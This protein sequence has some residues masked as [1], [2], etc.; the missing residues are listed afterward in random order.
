MPED[1]FKGFKN[2]PVIEELLETAFRKANKRAGSLKKGRS[3][4]DRL[5]KKEF[6]RVEIAITHVQDYLNSIVKSVP[7]ISALHPFYQDLCQLLVSKDDLKLQL[8]RISGT[9]RVLEKLKNGQ[10][11]KIRKA[12]TKSQ[13]MMLRK[14]AMGRLKS[15]LTKLKGAFKYLRDARSSLRSIPVIHFNL[16]AV[17]FAGYPN[18]GK[19]SCINNFCGST[20][21]V[22]QYPFTTKEI[23]IGTFNDDMNSIQFIDTPGILDRPMKNRNAIELKAI[24]AIKHVADLII[25]VID[26][27]FNCGYELERQINLLEEFREN[28]PDVKMMIIINK[29]DLIS[30]DNLQEAWRQIEGTKVS[31]NTIVPYSAKKRIGE[32][33]V[34]RNIKIELG[35]T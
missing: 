21:K 29:V 27:T 19:S 13:A 3:A 7:D 20:I 32:E 28:L 23:M 17:V 31:I 30:N 2:I 26:P 11:S 8:G 18:V 12:T 5:K 6:T 35:I 1:P 25:F 33:E 22:A 9:I 34:L 16:P 15:M 24:L 4:S 14:E 10:I